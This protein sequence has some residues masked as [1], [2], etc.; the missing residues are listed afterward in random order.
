MSLNQRAEQPVQYTPKTSLMLEFGSSSRPLSI[1]RA[2]QDIDAG[3]KLERKG[4]RRSHFT[5]DKRTTRC[6]LMTIFFHTLSTFCILAAMTRATNDT[7]NLRGS[8]DYEPWSPVIGVLTHPGDL[9]G[10]SPFIMEYVVQYLESAGLQVV[11]LRY[12][13]PLIHWILPSISG[14]YFGEGDLDLNLEGLYEQ[15]AA[16]IYEYAVERHK[17]NDPFPLLGSCQGHQ[18]LAALAA[19]TTDVIMKEKYE[20]SDIALNLDII[21]DGGTMLGSLPTEVQEILKT[22]AVTPNFHVNG[23][24]PEMWDNYPS[25]REQFKLTSTSKDPNGNVFSAS[26]ESQPGMPPMYSLQWHPEM[27]PYVWFYP[28]KDGLIKSKDAFRVSSSMSLFVAQLFRDKP[29]RF[30]SIKD[31]DSHLIRRS[32]LNCEKYGGGSMVSGLCEY[33]VYY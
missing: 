3:Q 31:L 7:H 4:L 28:L 19:G 1:V 17:Q 21:G 30:K 10:G 18:L 11:P 33:Q 13:D 32:P 24:P 5:G 9:L 15:T 23:V 20:T 27:V 22:K 25:L 12:A 14:V 26:M 6:S 2:P 16:K 29:H 8:S